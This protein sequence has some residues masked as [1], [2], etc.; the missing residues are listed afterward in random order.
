MLKE[1]N[2]IQKPERVVNVIVDRIVEMIDK[3]IIQKGERLP[4]EKD[5]AEAFG[6]GRSS[7]REAL[8]AL[9]L[10]GFIVTKKGVGRFLVKDKLDE[11]TYNL[12][13]WV[14]A[15]PYLQLLEAREHLEVL[16]I[17]LAVDRVT[18]E[19]IA[20]MKDTVHKMSL[21]VND[22]DRFYKTEFHFHNIIYEACGNEVLTELMSTITEKIFNEDDKI[23]KSYVRNAESAVVDAKK[24]LEA[25]IAADKKKA[26]EIM[27]K[28]IE[29]I[30][31]TYEEEELKPTNN[32]NDR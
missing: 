4:S 15:A 12:K 7:I 31:I 23:R 3:G 2:K 16:I 18:E 29:Q 8:Q 10:S 22:I 5:L 24:I 6:V 13:K 27:K 32:D 30:R 19:I 20:E 9:E 14:E 26:M 25:F 21:E 17:G 28:H 11:D 1:I